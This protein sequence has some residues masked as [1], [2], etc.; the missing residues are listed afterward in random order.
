MTTYLPSG[1]PGSVVADFADL[2]L[3]ETTFPSG[4]R[5]AVTASIHLSRVTA[6]LKSLAAAS[7][8]SPGLS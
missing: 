6:P 3:R 4:P 1:A 8:L 2:S 7:Q 5:A